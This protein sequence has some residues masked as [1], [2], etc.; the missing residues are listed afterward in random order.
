MVIQG[1]ADGFQRTYARP[2]D[3]EVIVFE[4]NQYDEAV[5]GSFD[6]DKSPDVLYGD[7]FQYLHLHSHRRVVPL[8]DVATRLSATTSSTIVE[9]GRGGGP[10]VYDALSGAPERARLQQGDVPQRGAWGVRR[11]REI[12]AWSLDSGRAS[13]TRSPPRF[14]KE[15]SR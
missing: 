15:A 2:V 5:E 14:P 13:W 7:Y 3:V 6:T 11:R 9:H 4:Q 12:T 10:R 8:D 1:M